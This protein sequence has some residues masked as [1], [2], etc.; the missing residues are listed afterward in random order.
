MS[1]HSTNRPSIA[2]AFPALLLGVALLAGCGGGG[3]APSREAPGA[4]PA[5]ELSE[6]LRQAR[7]L[8]AEQRFAEGAALVEEALGRYPESAELHY[9]LGVFLGLQSDHEGAARAFEQA[10]IHD[11]GH[12]AS[13]RA[14][15]NAYTGL[16]RLEEAVPYLEQCLWA[17]PGDSACRW[18]LGKNLSSLGRYDEALEHLRRATEEREGAEAWFELGLAL[19]RSGDLPAA[20]DAFAV[21]LA[22]EPEHQPTLLNYGQTLSAL[23]RSEDGNALLEVHR[24]IASLYDR[25]E[26]LER[27]SEQDDAPPG[28]YL[29]LADQYLRRNDPDAAELTYRNALERYG[30]LPPAALSLA[31]L[32]LQ[33][34]RTDEA[35]RWLD[36]FLASEPTSPPGLFLQGVVELRQGRMVEAERSFET[37]RR[38][39]PWTADLWVDLGE[40]YLSLGMV[41][42][43]EAAFHEALRLDPRLPVAHLGLAT[44]FARTGG[45]AAAVSS[46]RRALELDPG[47]ADAWLLLGGLAANDG[48]GPEATGFFA[49]ALTLLRPVLL[50]ADGRA[51]VQERLAER[52]DSPAGREL[53]DR[54]MTAR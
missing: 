41:R 17:D 54:A 30:E 45:V 25:I 42:P 27:R 2:E 49:N 3:E 32:L 26:A 14:L 8:H 10:L 35:V 48:R 18:L 11:A 46:T 34:G 36:R 38:G 40:E 23:G 9:N 44:A 24:Q 1:R 21:A 5:T 22:E 37:S 28:V 7:A 15:A 53:L 39:F 33:D 51:R 31:A 47:L 50:R 19:S 13:I 43:A 4:V 12:L 29:E 20:C 16:G 52:L 6:I